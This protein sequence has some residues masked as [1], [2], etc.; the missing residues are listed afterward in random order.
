MPLVKFSNQLMLPDSKLS[1]NYT[2]NIKKYQIL[3]HYWDIPVTN[4]CRDDEI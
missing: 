4:W 1:D 3:C 2:D